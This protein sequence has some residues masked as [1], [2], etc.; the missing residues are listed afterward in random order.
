[1]IPALLVLAVALAISAYHIGL[2]FYFDAKI[3]R[4]A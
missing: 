1:M 3:G 4:R 2:G